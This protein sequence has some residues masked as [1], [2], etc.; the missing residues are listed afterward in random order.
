MNWFAIW[1]IVVSMSLLF[2]RG[3]T[4]PSVNDSADA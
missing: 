2:I 4:R 1:M 3:A